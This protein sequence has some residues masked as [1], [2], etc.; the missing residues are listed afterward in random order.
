MFY[1]GVFPVS[2]GMIVCCWILKPKSSDVPSYE[3]AL[4]RTHFTDFF[5]GLIPLT[6]FQMCRDNIL[7]CTI[8]Y[9]LL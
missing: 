3:R 1:R 2:T 9:I 6:V 4:R 5:F 8:H 7:N